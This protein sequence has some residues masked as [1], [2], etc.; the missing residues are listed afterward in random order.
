[1][2][3]L[4][5]KVA[6][7]FSVLIL[8]VIATYAA[9]KEVGPIRTEL[10]KLLGSSNQGT[11]FFMTFHPCW[12]DPG[13]TG[14]INIYI[15]SA[16][17]TRVTVEIPGKGIYLQKTTIP[18]DI[19]NFTFSSG[20][21]QCY[22]KAPGDVPQPQRVFV[23]YGLI[24]TS[25]DPIVCYGMTRFFRVA[26]G[27]LGIPKS[28]LGKKYIVSSYNDLGDGYNSYTSIVGVYNKTR[29]KVRLG[30]RFSN[31]TP[32]A[33]SMKTNDV[34]EEVLNRGDV[35]LIG[36]SG[37]NNDLTGTSVE[38]NKQ[39]SVISGNFGTYVPTQTCCGDFLM[40]QDMPMESW[41]YK[42]HVTR[43]VKRLKSSLIRV[44]TSEPNTVIYRDGNEWSFVKSVGGEEGSGYIERRV[45]DEGEEP[46][47]VT[48]AAK[49]R[50]AVTQ[51]NTGTGDDNIDSD[52]FQLSLTPIEQYQTGF[53]WCT[54]G[55]NGGQFFTDNFLNL[56]YKA[57]EDGQIPDDVEF[58]KVSNGIV[59]WRKLSSVV[60]SAGPEFTD[61]SITDLRKY[62]TVTIVLEDPK[63]VY[64]LRGN[65]GMAGYGYGFGFHDGYGYPVSV[66]LADM[67]KP[68]IWAPLPTYTIDC[69]GNVQ[70]RVVEQPEY[71][72]ALRSNM[73][74]LRLVK[75]ESYNFTDIVYDEAEFVP[76]E[77]Y[78]LDWSL[79]VID[80]ESDAKAVLNFMDRAGNDTSITIDYQRTKFSINNRIENWGLKA[81]DDPPEYRTFKLVN[82][83]LKP[84][85]VDTL[86]LLSNEKG[87]NWAY[88][89]FKIDPAIYKENGGVLPGY[90]ILPGEELI[91]RVGFDPQ[92]VAAEI[93]AGKNQF[94]D[95]IG[96]KAYWSNDMK[97]Y[98][99]QKYRAAVKS[100][101]GS[102]CIAVDRLDF[103]PVTVN[104]TKD[105]A[106][107]IYNNGTSELTIIGYSLPAGAVDNIYVSSDLGLVNASNP[108]RIPTGGSK[109]FSVTFKPNDVKQFPDKI[110]FDSDADTN[111]AAHDP[112]LE[113]TGEG[114]KPSIELIGYDWP[115]LR[116]HLP[117]YDQP[118]NPYGT[119]TF[120]YSTEVN[121]TNTSMTISNTG[122]QEFTVTD[123]YIKNAI[124]P[125]YF[126]MDFNSDKTYDGAVEDNLNLLVGKTIKPNEI[127]TYPVFYDPK[128]EGDHTVTVVVKGEKDGYQVEGECTF[129]GTGIYPKGKTFDYMFTQTEPNSTAIVDLTH[130]G[131]DDNIEFTTDEWG[132]F[133][134]KLTI[135]DIKVVPAEGK[136]ISEDINIAG[137]SLFAFT[138][139]DIIFPIVVNP[140]DTFSFPA[141]Y[142][143]Y[144]TSRN[145][146]ADPFVAHIVFVTDAD[147]T[148]HPSEWTGKSVSQGASAKG[149]AINT[150]IKYE[151]YGIATITNTAD[152]EIQISNVF[153]RPVSGDASALSIISPKVF[154]LIAGESKDIQVQFQQNNPGMTIADIVFETSIKT[155]P[156]VIARLNCEAFSYPRKT[157]GKINDGL[158]PSNSAY[159]IGFSKDPYGG[160]TNKFKFSVEIEGINRDMVQVNKETNFY[161]DIVY[162]RNFLGAEF[163]NTKKQ[164]KVELGSGLNS[165]DYMIESVKEEMLDADK[166]KI[167]TTIRNVSGKPITS[168]GTLEIVKL[169]FDVFLNDNA[170][171]LDS[172]EARKTKISAVV[173]TNESCIPL[174]PNNDPYA[175]LQQVCVQNLRLI[176]IHESVFNLKDITPN[177]VGLNGADIN[178]TLGF[179][180]LVEMTIYNSVGS[181]VVKPVKEQQSEGA[182]SIAIPVNELASGVYFIEMK[183]G[184]FVG[185]K[186][187]VIQK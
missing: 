132:D 59:N 41:G 61:E 103:G 107:A 53:V 100:S 92:T 104:N 39:V 63:G 87:R 178:Y 168:K 171:Q 6:A 175:V 144:K 179:D 134:D 34:R 20:V 147:V 19:I 29:V 181:A 72:E 1:M 58:G 119:A 125:E 21:A 97:D 182:H 84:V 167:K 120:P 142:Y 35:W 166:S 94:L 54:P 77:T 186:R 57:T 136:G 143:P 117:I 148:E 47:P 95:S 70:G 38:A 15:T 36:A 26:D 32:G 16:V 176:E 4:F 12:Q 108:I 67:S 110:I 145:L 131:Y 177:P 82:E 17:A 184:P 105:L 69:F 109:A 22:D 169:N 2:K 73:A 138:K 42:Y 78:I 74:D 126:I 124:N 183:A 133:A 129:R 128:T 173:T 9:D 155:A 48:I 137:D 113:L 118:G 5:T 185:T 30:G 162:D 8:C 135:Y 51:Y 91:F 164:I 52:P 18:N 81:Y 116:V 56:C 170:I 43:F 3:N 66:A 99:Y 80:I 25:E 139:S 24:I 62:H 98:C 174:T 111:C 90:T 150:C 68:D 79:Q 44:F 76:G 88:N 10:V 151:E 102:P 86:L 50:I 101:T 165:A 115:R 152:G 89:G 31:K 46:R 149:F 122:T 172:L 158:H 121:G 75:S 159:E 146:G 45:V 180:C 114:I 140:G 187:L 64:A 106:F 153:I 40:E 127:Y 7:L 55:V 112:V 154:K 27:Y 14:E 83:S 163:D 60:S 28:G 160:A 11:E 141:K 156:E 157:S 49:N 23:G 65:D 37:P 123:A 13:G 71:D 161:V 130:Q 33:N 93:L 85:I 96:I